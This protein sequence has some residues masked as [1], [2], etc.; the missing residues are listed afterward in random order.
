MKK[1]IICLTKLV[2]VYII[3][4]IYLKIKIKI[5]ISSILKTKYQSIPT[6]NEIR[7]WIYQ[8]NVPANGKHHTQIA[9]TGV[10]HTR[11]YHS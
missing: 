5:E 11:E 8:K 10:S 9:F 1:N 3:F 6:A 2:R 7:E 4:L